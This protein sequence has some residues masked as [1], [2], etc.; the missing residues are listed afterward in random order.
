VSEGFRVA[1]WRASGE[2][3]MLVRERVL[4]IWRAGSA[5]EADVLPAVFA[6]GGILGFMRE[7]KLES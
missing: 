5:S 4:R 6:P 2:V 7:K 3:I 1:E